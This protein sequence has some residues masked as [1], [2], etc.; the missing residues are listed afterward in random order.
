MV[1]M[2][3]GLLKSEHRRLCEQP[4]E[5]GGFP[6]TV[7]VERV[8]GSMNVILA[9]DGAPGTDIR[10]SPAEVKATDPAK[11]VIRLE[12]RLSGMESPKT[13][14]LAEIDQLTAEAAHGRD[15]DRR[16]F[17]QADHLD[18]ARD[19][20]ARLNKQLGLAAAPKQETPPQPVTDND[21]WLARAAMHD[22]TVMAG[23]PGSS[24]MAISYYD[25]EPESA[26]HASQHDFPAGNPLTGASD[27][28]DPPPPGRPRPPGRGASPR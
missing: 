18:A 13:R 6:V 4:G 11:L 8:L 20:A 3:D 2:Y 1:Q 17:T 5:L 7:T 16:P 14:T 21:D 19:R 12:N 28:A 9:L 26:V 15:V 27:A 24:V 10:M 22:A 23:I 25:S